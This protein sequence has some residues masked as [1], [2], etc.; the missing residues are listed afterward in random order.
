MNFTTIRLIQ[1]ENKF[2][3]SNNSSRLIFKRGSGDEMVL[4]TGVFGPKMASINLMMVLATQI[5]VGLS[6]WL[7]EE[8]ARLLSDLFVFT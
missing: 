7:N 8:Q 2:Q 4:R 6:S 1:I 3:W 5:K